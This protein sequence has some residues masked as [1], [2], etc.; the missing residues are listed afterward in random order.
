MKGYEFSL[1]DF[2]YLVKIVSRHHAKQIAS[3]V[4]FTAHTRKGVTYFQ[5]SNGNE[6]PLSDVYRAIQKATPKVQRWTYNLHFF[7]SHY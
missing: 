1:D 3:W 7:Y 4:G 2:T 6:V 5:N